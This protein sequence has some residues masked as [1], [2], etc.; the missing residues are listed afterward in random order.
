M[1]TVNVPA[2]RPSLEE[3]DP[4]AT[5]RRALTSPTLAVFSLVAIFALPASS[6]AQEKDGAP[7]FLM[8]LRA[9][10]IEDKVRDRVVIRGSVDWPDGRTTT[11]TEI[12]CEAN[13][14]SLTVID[15]TVNDRLTAPAGS[16]SPISATCWRAVYSAG[17]SGRHDQ[18]Q[19][20]R[21]A[22]GEPKPF[23][24]A[25]QGARHRHQRG[26]ARTNS[27]P[28]RPSLQLLQRSNRL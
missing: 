24:R 25:R 12:I 3:L 7:K 17:G 13:R 19:P 21:R 26:Q 11:T 1:R 4:A 6:I 20:R 22:A 18:G 14:R 23:R 5:R 8:P 10:I 15:R 16:S 2:Q 27:F 28:R 9:D